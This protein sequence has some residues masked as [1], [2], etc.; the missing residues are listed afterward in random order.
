MQVLKKLIKHGLVVAFCLLMLESSG[1]FYN[2]LKM[3]FGKNRVLY[4]AILPTKKV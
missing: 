1:Q 3:D 4:M 2:G